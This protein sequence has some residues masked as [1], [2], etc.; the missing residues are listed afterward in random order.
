MRRLLHTAFIAAVLAAILS[1]SGPDNIYPGRTDAPIYPDY[2]DVTIPCNIAPLNF[3]YVK[4]GSGNSITTFE[5]NGGRETL[6]GNKPRWNIRKW[7]RM[8]S[9]AAGGDIRVSSSILDTTWTLHVSKD[10][11]DYAIDYRLIEP[12]YEVYSK[13]GIYER[14]LSD[15]NERALVENTEF[16]GCVNCHSYNRGDSDDF[17]LHIRGEHGATL[18]RKNGILD[19]YNT[20]TDQTLGFCVYPYWHPSGRYIVYS[21]NATRQGF[22]VGRDKLIEVFDSASD[23]QVYD[24]QANE[25]ITAPS[26][27]VDSLWETFPSFSP[28]GCTIYF[29]RAGQKAI[30]DGL[31]NVRY[32][33]CSVDF[34]PSTGQ[35]G[36]N[37]TV[38]LDAASEGKSVSFPKPSYDGRFIMYTLSDYG[39]FSIWH[40]EAD[41]WLLDLVTGER[42]CLDTVNSADTESYHNFSSTSRWFVFSSRRDDGL[43]TRPYFSHIDEN[44]NVTKA[45][46]LPQENPSEFYGTRFLSFNVPEFVTSP[47][48]FDK[49]KMRKLIDSDKR[50]DFAYRGSVL[51]GI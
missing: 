4:G 41:L 36:E 46:M 10:T 28:D 15:F 24:T 2:M 21:T 34:D 27:K 40:H 47:V 25:L 8:L 45:F 33:L 5:W 44:G 22:H 16:N 11:I 23:L 30:P 6:R 1:C 26:V 13:M 29:C 19:A 48:V 42:R 38:L 12:G 9:E 49:I 18:I 3:D 43:F 7:R 32:N 14:C 39:Q 51:P 37:V 31:M 35:I 50:T 20:K 17:S